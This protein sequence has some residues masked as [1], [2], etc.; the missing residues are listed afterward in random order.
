MSESLV[1]WQPIPY[2]DQELF[3]DSVLLSG[4][5]VEVLMSSSANA[6][7]Q[8]RIRFDDCP[9]VRV[10]TEH[11][12]NRTEW[13]K[14]WAQSNFWTVEDSAHRQW[15]LDRTGGVYDQ[16]FTNYLIFTAEDCVDLLT[17]DN[18]SVEWIDSVQKPDLS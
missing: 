15:L 17:M 18:P 14:A 9:S 10:H 11:V 4:N 16:N 7:K 2:Q 8:L 6:D 5:S 3:V 1:P 12:Y 13:M